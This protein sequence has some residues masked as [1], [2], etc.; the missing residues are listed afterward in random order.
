MSWPR[1]LWL[2]CQ[3]I[4]PLFNQWTLT[5]WHASALCFLLDA[6]RIPIR[7]L[8]W[9]C[10]APVKLHVSEW[11]SMRRSWRAAWN[12]LD[13]LKIDREVVFEGEKSEVLFLIFRKEEIQDLKN[14]F[15]CL[16]SLLSHWFCPSASTT[17][18]GSK[19]C[20]RPTSNSQRLFA[21]LRISKKGFRFV[22]GFLP[23]KPP[24]FWQ[25]NPCACGLMKLLMRDLKSDPHGSIYLCK[26]QRPQLT[27]T[28]WCVI[29][30]EG[31][32]KLSSIKLH[33]LNIVVTIGGHFLKLQMWICEFVLTLGGIFNKTLI[34]SIKWH[35]CGWAA[36]KDLGHGPWFF[37]LGP[38]HLSRW[39]GQMLKSI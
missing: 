29:V 10:P 4:Q 20:L 8:G 11:M 37:P 2:G 30:G 9:K 24:C 33:E 39:F 25:K 18:L 17:F 16:E 12:K 19:A 38:W 7:V 6:W 27:S 21:D 28:I 32:P 13:D 3:S 35:F 34:S 31:I 15:S 26:V 22:L 36:S 14:D 23:L 5:M 1:A